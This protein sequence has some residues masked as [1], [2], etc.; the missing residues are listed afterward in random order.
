VRDACCI[1]RVRWIVKMGGPEIDEGKGRNP[2]RSV[3]FH[4]TPEYQMVFLQV[5]DGAS[6]IE[7]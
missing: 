5:F 4:Q 7:C 6:P 1:W 2:A 3:Y